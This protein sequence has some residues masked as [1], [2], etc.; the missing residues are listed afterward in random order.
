MKAWTLPSGIGEKTVL[1]QFKDGSGV[2]SAPYGDS[3][4]LDASFEEKSFNVTVGS[5]VYVVTTRSNASVSDF[6]F[7]Q[8]LKRIRFSCNASS[9]AAGFCNVTVPAALL[10]GEFSLFR[11]DVQLVSGVGY[12]QVYNGTHYTFNVGYGSGVHATEIFGT[13]VIPEFPAAVLMLS[14]MLGSALASGF[15]RGLKPGQRA[16]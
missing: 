11:D 3:I 16:R 2:E 9:G 8:V 1:A 5:S 6:S 7:N 12:V 15:R 14:L 10:W 13:S 4:L